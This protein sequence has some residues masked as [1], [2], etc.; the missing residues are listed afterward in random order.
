MAASA[1]ASALVVEPT[2]ISP[3]YESIRQ[4]VRE[5]Y[6]SFEWHKKKAN[7][8]DFMKRLTAIVVKQ[9]TTLET[10]ERVSLEHCMKYNEIFG[11]CKHC[12]PYHSI[13]KKKEIKGK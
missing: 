11:N 8:T 5:L 9:D 2:S 4:C 1:D 10:M 3:E 12:I 13:E 6:T 7:I